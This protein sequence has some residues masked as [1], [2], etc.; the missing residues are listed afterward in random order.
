VLSSIG[1]FREEYVHH[2]EHRRCLV[3]PRAAAEVPA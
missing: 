2:V 3:E 1:K